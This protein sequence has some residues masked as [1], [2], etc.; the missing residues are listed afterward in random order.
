[1]KHLL[2]AATCCLLSFAASA[3]DT[4]MWRITGF[5]RDQ[6]G[7]SLPGARISTGDSTTATIADET[8]LFHLQLSRPYAVIAVQ[9]LGYAPRSIALR[10]TDF[11][12]KTLHLDIVLTQQNTV[13]QEVDIAVRKVEV[14]IKEDYQTHIFD[15]DLFGDNL[16]LLL[17][18]RKKHFIRLVSAT[19]RVLDELELAG[20]PTILHRSCTGVF[21]L[22]GEDF[23][24]EVVVLQE[25]K[26]DTLPRYDPVVFRTQVEPC[27][28]E[29]KGYYF[30]RQTGML[31]QSIRY[32]YYEPSGA[33]RPFVQIV[34]E[35]GLK[36]MHY[37]LE[38]ML[39][40]APLVA[41][42]NLPPN[43]RGQPYD[44]GFDPLR[45]SYTGDFGTEHLLTMAWSNHQINHLGW[46][47]S[48]RLDSLYAPLIN[49]GDT[50]LLFD[51]EHG[52]VRRFDARLT[53][54]EIL[55]VDFHRAAGWQKRILKDAASR[56]LY[57]HCKTEGTHL[58]KQLHPRT[59]EP[60]MTYR[61][62]EPAYLTHHFRVHNGFF[63][64][65]GRE[66]PN[67]PN[68]SLYKINLSRLGSSGK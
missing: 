23:A 32:W 43:W 53:K 36:E 22:V 42:P 40:G 54:T 38:S 35:A 4:S 41:E 51:T 33:M 55:P 9:R 48:L 44:M 6:S 34:R 10:A 68:G 14:L 24:Q 61:L 47:E 16:L 64:F 67:I 52:E 2:F 17:R 58:L 59:F 27:V 18:V 25:K 1:M 30:F 11:S 8:G 13:L 66:N 62:P 50:L 21:H 19:N 37:A 39:T 60:Q 26:L 56:K 29:N 46:L 45:P 5:I 63:Y 20:R 49:M 31:S 7:E 3:Q 65:L 28:L 15:Y 12:E 57:A